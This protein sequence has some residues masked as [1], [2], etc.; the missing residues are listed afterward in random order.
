MVLCVSIPASELEMNPDDQRDHDSLKK[1]LDRVGKAIMMSAETEIA[2][3]IRRRLFEWGGLPDD[4]R[5]TAAEYAEWSVEH[6]QELSG[7]DADSALES[8]QTCYPFHPS[9]LSVFE[10]KWQA[11]PRFQR[12][13][14]VLRLLALWVAH[15]YQDEHRKAMREPLITLGSAPLENPYFRSAMFEQ[16]G[17]NELEIPVTTD[18]AGKKDAHALR[19][20]REA[21]EAIK[22]AN[23][24]RKV[25]ATIFFESNGGMSQ[26]KAEAA[27]PEIRTGVGGPELNLVD[28]ENVLEGLVGTCYYLNGDR[29]RY[30]FGLT[31]NLNQIL[32]TRRGAVQPKEINERINKQTQELFNLGSK[33]IDRRFFPERSNDVPNRP[34]L[35]FVVLGLDHPASDKTTDQ[36]MES[37][38]RDCGSSGRTYKS[39]PHLHR[40][41]FHRANSCGDTRFARVGSD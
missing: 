9:V 20:D 1:L 38:V 39:A 7:I 30:R 17:S 26:S 8:F 22:K 28:V 18:I 21:P 23:L 36:L 15:A 29:N 32:V 11:L 5:K 31:P 35:T 2:E 24:H 13:R 4:A 19:L 12:T 33:E 37:I 3:I 6:S 16:L 40:T 41:R 34:V 14:G 25:A 10:R 27:L